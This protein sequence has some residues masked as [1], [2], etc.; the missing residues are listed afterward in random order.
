MARVHRTT[1]T[2]TLLVTM[3]VSALAGC[4]TVHGPVPAGPSA[5]GT[6][7]S[8]PRPD[9]PAEPRVVQ[10]PARE[11]LE[12]IG[13]SKAPDR[14][15]GEP[16]RAAPPADPPRER[17][18]AA[19]AGQQPRPGRPAAPK[20]T[21]PPERPGAG[22]PSVPRPPAPVTGGRTDVCS[23]GRTYGGWRPGSPEAVICERAYGH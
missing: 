2:A 12:M 14:A 4:T 7:S 8:G 1:T 23:L 9:G 20:G 13:P 22:V 21:R 11:A 6:R 18:P 5:A 10:A 19:R 3:A 15:S 16:R 17:P